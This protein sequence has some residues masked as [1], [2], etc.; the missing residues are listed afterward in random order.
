M[1]WAI[2]RKREVV[3]GVN[4]MERKLGIMRS[5][6][7]PFP[8]ALRLLSCLDTDY[9]TSAFAYLYF[10]SYSAYRPNIQN[11]AAGIRSAF[12]LC[13]NFIF[14]IPSVMLFRYSHY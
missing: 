8:C 4:P 9:H 5:S 11:V 13:M 10:P 12:D 7:F 2:Q 6:H 14:G 1:Q 3:F